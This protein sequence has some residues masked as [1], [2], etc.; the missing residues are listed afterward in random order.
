MGP[1]RA[2]RARSAR[3]IDEISLVSA[4]ALARACDASACGHWFG[5]KIPVSVGLTQGGEVNLQRIYKLLGVE[6]C[7]LLERIESSRD[8]AERA[9][10]TAGSRGLHIVYELRDGLPLHPQSSV[11]RV[12]SVV[13]LGVQFG[14]QL[15]HPTYQGDGA[16]VGR[17]PRLAPHARPLRSLETQLPACGGEEEEEEEEGEEREAKEAENRLTTK[18]HSLPLAIREELLAQLGQHATTHR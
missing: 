12:A 2:S 7:L 16:L 11:E 15:H 5:S 18:H 13:L 17:L 10:R 9:F 8:L 6:V 14:L 3:A 4:C 1:R